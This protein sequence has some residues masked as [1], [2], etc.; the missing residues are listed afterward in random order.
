MAPSNKQDK[1]F[2]HTSFPSR[3]TFKPVSLYGCDVEEPNVKYFDYQPGL[4]RSF[5][6]CTCTSQIFR[7]SFRFMYMERTCYLITKNFLQLS[8]P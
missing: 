1:F 2:S 3:A 6:T 4:F 7:V 5:K 8:L